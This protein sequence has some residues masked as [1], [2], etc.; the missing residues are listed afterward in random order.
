MKGYVSLSSGGIRWLVVLLCVWGLH[1]QLKYLGDRCL[2]GFGQ[3]G[4]TT[5]SEAATATNHGCM[6]TLPIFLNNK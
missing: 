5:K 1:P 3:Y 6:Q 4:V 2:S